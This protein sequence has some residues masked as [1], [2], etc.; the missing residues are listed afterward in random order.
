M[1]QAATPSALVHL[2][3]EL[4]F[5]YINAAGRRMLGLPYEEIIGLY[6][7]DLF[8]DMGPL[9]QVAE[10][11]LETGEAVEM[12]EVPITVPRGE[13]QEGRVRRFDM[14]LA[15]A[16]GEDGAIDGLVVSATDVTEKVEQRERTL[17]A[18]RERAQLAENLNNEIAHRVKNNL[19]MVSGLLQMQMY[20]HPEPELSDLLRDAITWVRTFAH[21]HE[22]MY[23]TG[24]EDLDLCESMQRLAGTVNEVYGTTT[25][26]TVTVEGDHPV[27]R[28][29]A[30]TNLTIVANELLTNAVKHGRPEEDGTVHIDVRVR[31]EEGVLRVSIWNSGDSLPMG[32]D[33]KE[34]R[35]MGLRLVWD[36]VVEQYG[37]RLELTR[38]DEGVLAEVELEEAALARS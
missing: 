3:R 24:Q 22:Q 26:M 32:F 1:I 2:D 7:H 13:G 28:S 12:T 37:G 27:Y 23:A 25:P 38:R 21:I 34:N 29:R 33:V 36:V 18:E 8:P 10:H 5:V 6:P 4:R 30:V 19:A 35:S 9:K 20:L 17:E 15:P 31:S 14:T 16:R 11:I